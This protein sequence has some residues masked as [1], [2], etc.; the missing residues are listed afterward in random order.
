MRNIVIVMV[1][2]IG[3]NG[4]APVD[5]KTDKDLSKVVSKTE[6]EQ[7]RL[8]LSQY[9]DAIQSAVTN[10]WIHPEGTD[11][12]LKC[13][14][15]VNQIPGGNVIDITTDTPCNASNEEKNSFIEAVIKAD[16]LPYVGFESVFERRINFIFQYQGD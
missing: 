3:L 8:L 13:L 7:R 10:K 9:A 4:C 11:A 2:I 6:D 16:P 12:G 5:V 1:L 15:K 14:I